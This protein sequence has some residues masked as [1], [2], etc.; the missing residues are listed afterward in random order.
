MMY[1]IYVYSNGKA[2]VY[3]NDNN[4]IACFSTSLD[5]EKWLIHVQM[6]DDDDY[7]F[8]YED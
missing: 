2:D 8:A 4:I 1:E 5:A 7:T 6:N 3:D